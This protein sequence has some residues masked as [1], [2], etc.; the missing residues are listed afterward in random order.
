MLTITSHLDIAQQAAS[1]AR[2]RASAPRYGG[3]GGRPPVVVWNLT[4]RCNQRCAHCY[5]SACTVASP[6]ELDTAKSRQ[7]LR[8]LA[9]ARVPAV[10]FSGGEPLLRDDLLELVQL[11]SSLGVRPM[12][13]SNGTLANEDQLA[14]LADAGL[15]YFGVSIDGPAVFNDGF[16][17]MHRGYERAVR[18]LLAGKRVGLKTGLRMTVTSQNA[19]EVPTMFALA[20]R[21][22]AA[23]FYVSHLV[24][25]GRGSNVTALPPARTRELLLELFDMALSARSEG[26]EVEVVTGG[27]DS[28]GPLFLRWLRE[29]LGEVPAERVRA[30]LEARGGNTSAVGLLCIDSEGLVHPDQFWRSEV[31]GDLNVSS[32][33]EILNNPL[34]ARLAR[35]AEHLKGRCGSCPHVS[36]CGGGHRERALAEFGDVWASDPSCVLIDAE[37]GSRPES[38]LALAEGV[39]S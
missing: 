2:L 18:G 36:L 37:V 26:S 34:R 5:V 14:A 22:G 32:F 7:V 31:L 4:D 19:G 39:A 12:L 24:R 13:S 17:G 11:A 3:V 1:P 23:R 8:A 15:Q 25:V 38:R 29:R 16:R 6:T 35:R 9:E 27:N 28:A 20:E 30:L 10:V 21:V 33:E